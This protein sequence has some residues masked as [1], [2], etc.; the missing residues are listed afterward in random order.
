MKDLLSRYGVDTEDEMNEVF[1]RG[2][3][4]DYLNDEYESQSGSYRD[5]MSENALLKAH[6]AEDRWD[7]VKLILNGKGLD[8]NEENIQMFL[9]THPEWASNAASTQFDAPQ[10]QPSPLQGEPASIQEGVESSFQPAS[11]NNRPVNQQQPAATLRKLGH[12]TK[13]EPDTETEE[14]RAN[15]LFGLK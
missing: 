14:Q 13:S 12:E 11:N 5:V 6:I 3:A 7:D 2:Q 10:Q 15:K 1:G 9:P 4:Y 8:V